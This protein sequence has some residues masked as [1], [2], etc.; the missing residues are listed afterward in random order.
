LGRISKPSMGE[1]ITNP[2]RIGPKTNP[3][4][5]AWFIFCIVIDL[6]FDSI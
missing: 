3:I 5:L 6:I 2:K 4:F 1:M